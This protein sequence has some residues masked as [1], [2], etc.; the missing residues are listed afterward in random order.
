VKKAAVS[1]AENKNFIC[2]IDNDLFLKLKEDYVAEENAR[3]V[4]EG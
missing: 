3:D 1:E 4:F 2:Y